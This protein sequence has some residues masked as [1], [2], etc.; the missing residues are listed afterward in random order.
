MIEGQSFVPEDN[1]DCSVP[2]VTDGYRNTSIGR[3]VEMVTPSYTLFG[4]ETAVLKGIHFKYWPDW[5]VFFACFQVFTWYNKR[6]EY[7]ELS[8]M[9]FS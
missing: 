1:R 4:K 5:R 6:G 2:N 9:I 8:T 3:F 7:V